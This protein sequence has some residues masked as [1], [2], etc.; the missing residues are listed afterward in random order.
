MRDIPQECLL[1][2]RQFHVF[3]PIYSKTYS[4]RV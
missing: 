1:L 2:F 4:L 3:L